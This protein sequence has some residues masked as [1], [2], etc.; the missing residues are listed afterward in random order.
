MKKTGLLI[1]ATIGCLAAQSAMA[2]EA[3]QAPRARSRAI[4]PDS[5][6]VY[7][8]NTSPTNGYANRVYA[9]AMADVYTK[10]GVGIHA[11]VSGVSREEDAA[12]ASIGLSYAIAPG[13]RPRITAGTSTNTRNIYP[14]VY[15]SGQVRVEAG[16]STI[17]TPSFSWR[18]FRNDVS[19]LTPALDVAHYF[20]IPGDSGGFYAVQG[21]GT[22][23]FIDRAEMAYSISGGILTKRRSGISLGIHGEGGRLSY[24]GLNGPAG[25]FAPGF[26]SPYWAIRPS[27][28]FDIGSGNEIFLR[29]EYSHN[30]AFDTRGVL[31]GFKKTFE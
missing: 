14:E 12:F 18:A 16:K 11:D 25:T 23:S 3:Q 26:R 21:R 1:A 7:A 2:Q 31:I 27:L 8:G 22:L 10:K 15:V 28:G 30:D 5:V 13:V 20:T 6:T 24:S 19:E 9:G 29:G 4:P 17:I